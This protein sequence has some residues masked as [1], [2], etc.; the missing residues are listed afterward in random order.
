[1]EDKQIRHFCPPHIGDAES[2]C[3]CG[4]PD[5]RAYLT[6]GLGRTNCVDCLNVARSIAKDAIDLFVFF[7]QGIMQDGSVQEKPEK[8]KKSNEQNGEPKATSDVL[9]DIGD[10]VTDMCNQK[11]PYNLLDMCNQ[12]KPYNLLLK[13][14]YISQMEAERVSQVITSIHDPNFK[15]HIP[16]S[17]YICG[18]INVCDGHFSH[19]LKFQ[20]TDITFEKTLAE[21]E[22]INEKIRKARNE[23]I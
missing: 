23:N 17:K 20:A 4:C 2:F 6:T 10:A 5:E 12:K 7:K 15:E 1:M 11:K 21:I 8:S 14:C 13:N 16:I 3:L 22:E 18:T 9:P 19:V